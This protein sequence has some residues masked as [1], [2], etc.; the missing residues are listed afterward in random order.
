MTNMP[1][2][3]VEFRV[4]NFSPNPGE[5]IIIMLV[6]GTPTDASKKCSTCPLKEKSVPVRPRLTV[7]CPGYSDRPEVVAKFFATPNKGPV[8]AVPRG[9]CGL[10]PTGKSQFDEEF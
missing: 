6:K 2:N 9:R 8:N 10:D 4:L 5:K 1:K 7:L 3:A